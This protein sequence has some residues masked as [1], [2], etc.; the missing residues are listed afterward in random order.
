MSNIDKNLYSRQ[1]AVYGMQSMKNLSN[2]KVTIFNFNSSALELCKNLILTGI[3]ELSIIS[4]KKV[5]IDDLSYNY[6]LNEKDLGNNILKTI[7]NKLSDLNPYVKIN[8]N[9]INDDY[10]VLILINDT[11]ETANFFNKKVRKDNK[12]FIWVNN[13]GLMGN[14][15]CDFGNNYT[16]NDINGEPNNTSLLKNILDNIF[17]CIDSEP[18]NL[19]KGDKFKLSNHDKI[20]TIEKI[21]NRFKFKVKNNF[22]CMYES[23]C[24]ISEIKKKYTINF[25]PLDI[26]IKFPKFSNY[27]S[28]NL[29]KSFIQFHKFYNK[30]NRLPK[31]WNKTDFD[32]LNL[33]EDYKYNKYFGNTINTDFLPVGSIIG[34]YA[35]QEVIKCITNKFTPNNQWFYYNCYDILPNKHYV[36]NI[37]VIDKYIGLK[38]IFGSKIITKLHNKSLF[39]VGTGAIGCEHLKHFSMIGFGSKKSKIVITD[40][41]TIERSN[42]NRQFL[43]KNEHIGQLKSNIAKQEIFKMNSDVNIISHQNKIGCET[44]KVYDFKFYN[45]IDCI[46]NALDNVDTRLY[47]DKQCI[48]YNKPLFESG[49]L[50]TKGNTQIII[51]KVSENYGASNDQHIEQ[52]PICTIKNFPYSIEH[53]IHWAR[54][55]FEE[56][57]NKVP[58]SLKMYIKDPSCLDN[59]T[60]NEK[61]EIINNILFLFNNK[62]I[63]YCDCIIYALDK[64]TNIFNFNIAKILKLYPKDL[65]TSS[66]IPFWSGNKI[67]P[68][69]IIFDHNNK[70]HRSYVYY[71]SILFAEMFNIEITNIIFNDI[72]INYQT[73]KLYI[74]NEYI[75][76]TSD[77]EEEKHNLKQYIDLDIDELPDIELLKEINVNVIIF[78]KDND[79]NNHINYIMSC[80]NLRA[81]NYNIKTIDFLETKI[82]A[83]KIVP[84]ISTS[85]SIVSGLI[86]IEL[87]KYFICENN[88]E[89]FKN[90]YFNLGIS[91]FEQSE[92]EKCSTYNI[93]NKTYT[94]WDYIEINND[95]L[96]SEL[97]EYLN[98]ILNIKINTIIYKSKMLISSFL[99]KKTLEKRLKMKLSYLLNKFNIEEKKIYELQIDNL[100]MDIELPNLKFI[101]N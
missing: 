23:G 84:A 37:L 18:H 87:I 86:T 79:V 17:T 27:N 73:P 44:E 68:T 1:L 21:I 56:L 5:V 50:G 51:P 98:N 33:D 53:T 59:L 52:F 19:S 2:A 61:G 28:T 80:S 97:F 3:S 65:K 38:K 77:K 46:I 74:N 100:N 45:N 62:P 15:F 81:N 36:E 26:S 24:K 83:G 72:L 9:K 8:I 49:T 82:K 39:I 63:N 42:L 71:T 30:H 70:D 20:F 78:E 88:L 92:L 34:S 40:M 7:Q 31:C 54:N 35:A 91:Y 76:N 96:I 94:K 90:T 60:G 47:M 66:G 99:S 11:L 48:F 13:Y 6:Y 14:V 32:K 89:T 22:N 75:I 58:N 43:F 10:D 57:F 95:L 25:L 16:I 64:F 41:D 93:N 55:D 101:T 29:H 85:T 69:R 12:K 67:F 4:Y